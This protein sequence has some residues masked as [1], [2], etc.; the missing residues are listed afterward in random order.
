M[1]YTQHVLREHKRLS[2]E[3][4]NTDEGVIPETSDWY[5][6]R[7]EMFLR[8]VNTVFD[9]KDV[10]DDTSPDITSNWSVLRWMKFHRKNVF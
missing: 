9:L 1:A 8:K 5:D 6:M 4:T 2:P 10:L 7:Y 3:N